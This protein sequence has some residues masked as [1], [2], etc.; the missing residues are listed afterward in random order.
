MKKA[1]ALIIF[2]L[3]IISLPACSNLRG[4][5]E[6]AQ[7]IRVSVIGAETIDMNMKLRADYGE[8]ASDFELHFTGNENES[9][10]D[11]ISP[12]S[13][14][15]F[16]IVITGG[17]VNTE[18]DGVSLYMG[19]LSEIDETPACAVASII[20]AWK[21]GYITNSKFELY[22]NKETVALTICITDAS[23]TRTWFDKE[24]LLPIHAELISEGKAIL[25]CD[26]S[27][28]SF[29]ADNA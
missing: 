8:K 29:R 26:F 15:G 18:F 23:E 7:D 13:I 27:D 24:T 19:K 12:P 21:S 9:I 5:E 3:I 1:A 17:E 16:Q 2:V 20:T 14:A 25:F 22:D 28:V 6:V 4:A 11:V 10:I